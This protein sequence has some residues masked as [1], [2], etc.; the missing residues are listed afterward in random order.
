MMMLTVKLFIWR[1]HEAPRPHNSAELI[2]FSQTS[3][4]RPNASISGVGPMLYAGDV[5]LLQVHMHSNTKQSTRPVPETA[6]E[7]A[8]F[9]TNAT[10]PSGNLSVE[11]IISSHLRLVEACQIYAIWANLLVVFENDTR[12]MDYKPQY[13]S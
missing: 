1:K 9:M 2:N 13:I 5:M 7:A 8:T 10:M 3:S 12:T 6:R 11:D 4:S